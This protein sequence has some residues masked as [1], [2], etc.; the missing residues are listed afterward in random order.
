M[1]KFLVIL[2]VS[3]GI[4]VV[5]IW[6]SPIF[7]LSTNLRCP[8]CETIP[9]TRIIDGDTFVSGETRIRLYGMD[10]PEIGEKCADEATERLK[11]LAG[12]TVRVE[13]GPRLTD[14]Y[15]RSLAYVYT[16]SGL[17][18]DELLVKEGLAV[19]WTRDGRHMDYL[20]DLERETKSE[21]IGCLWK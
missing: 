4:L 9:V 16:E 21:G 5:L 11:K 10:T 1:F 8:D 15:G 20:M 2:A 7:V 13:R 3:I 14:V 17:S 12:D 19:A 6:L 18:I